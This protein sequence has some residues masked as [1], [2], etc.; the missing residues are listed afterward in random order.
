MGVTVD[1]TLAVGRWEVFTMAMILTEL[2]IDM[3]FV[4]K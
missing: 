4:N 1:N 3:P 2:I